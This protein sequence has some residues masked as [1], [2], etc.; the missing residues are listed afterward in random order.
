MDWSRFSVHVGIVRGHILVVSLDLFQEDGGANQGSNLSCTHTRRRGG[1][2]S[3]D[4]TKVCG[5]QTASL[6][7]PVKTHSHRMSVIRSCTTKL[8]VHTTARRKVKW[9]IEHW[10]EKSNPGYAL[11]NINK[12]PEAA[13]FT[14]TAN[15]PQ[16]TVKVNNKLDGE[17]FKILPWGGFFL[18]GWRHPAEL[19]MKTPW[20]TR[21]KVD[22]H[23]LSLS[24]GDVGYSER[25]EDDG[26][27]IKLG[28]GGGGKHVLVRW[29]LR[30]SRVSGVSQDDVLWRWGGLTEL[31]TKD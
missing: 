29:R 25:G 24:R 4:G 19:N 15:K 27:L 7:P 16:F 20:P 21:V 30:V 13:S 17:Q 2:K 10:K 8:H 11:L 3:R 23:S 9:I 22:K 6:F 31:S 18:K 5:E 14:V 26:F 12:I 1:V 28:V